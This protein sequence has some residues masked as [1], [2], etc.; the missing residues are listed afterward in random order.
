MLRDVPDML[1]IGD[2]LREAD[3]KARREFSGFDTEGLENGQ[4]RLQTGQIVNPNGTFAGV[5]ERNEETMK[6]AFGELAE[7]ENERTK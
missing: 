1:K 7:A 4:F 2:E 6:R 3:Y 5:D